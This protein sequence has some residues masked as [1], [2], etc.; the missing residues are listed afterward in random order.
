[1]LQQPKHVEKDNQ[2]SSSLSM[3]WGEFFRIFHSFPTC[4][5]LKLDDRN[6]KSILISYSNKFAI[7]C[8][9]SCVGTYLTQKKK[10]VL[11]NCGFLPPIL[12]T[13]YHIYEL[14]WDY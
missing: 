8:S 9:V 4:Q 12:I 10:I 2:V 3:N 11:S 14:T 1:M 7:V 13:T 5:R 6:C